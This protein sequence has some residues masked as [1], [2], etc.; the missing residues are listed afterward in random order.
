MRAGRLR[1]CGGECEEGIDLDAEGFGRRLIEALMTRY[2]TMPLRERSKHLEFAG[3]FAAD[4]VRLIA[5][6]LKADIVRAA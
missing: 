3:R 4:W 6:R 5:R 2:E 1:C